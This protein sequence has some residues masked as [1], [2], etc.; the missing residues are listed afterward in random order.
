MTTVVQLEQY[1][2]SCSNQII[3][4]FEKLADQGPI[5]LGEWL[6]MYGEITSESISNRSI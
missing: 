6:Q 5:D 4:Q 2:D 3:R 1:V